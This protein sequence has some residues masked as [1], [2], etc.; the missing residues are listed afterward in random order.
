MLNKSL[1]ASNGSENL[2]LVF[3]WWWSKQ[4]DSSG[5]LSSC[6]ANCANKLR[7]GHN[8]QYINIIQ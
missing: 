4:Q 8:Y 2:S 7:E 3:L 6:T 1:P 5:S